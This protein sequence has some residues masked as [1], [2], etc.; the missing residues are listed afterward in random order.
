MSKSIPRPYGFNPY[1]HVVKIDMEK[2]ELR[3]AAWAI[4]NKGKCTCDSSTD[5]NGRL[6]CPVHPNYF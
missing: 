6:Y 1:E 4:D 2:A 3:V 5:P